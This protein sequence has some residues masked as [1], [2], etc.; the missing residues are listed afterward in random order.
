MCFF[1]MLAGASYRSSSSIMIQALGRYF[2]A[3]TTTATG[4]AAATALSA[5]P[6]W[7]VGTT[8]HAQGTMITTARATANMQQPG[9]RNGAANVVI[10]AANATTI[11]GPSGTC[12]M[13]E[14][15]CGKQEC[16]LDSRLG[17]PGTDCLDQRCKGVCEDENCEQ[18]RT[19][20]WSLVIS[21]ET[22]MQV[23]ILIRGESF[24]SGQHGSREIG[25]LEM[26]RA[27]KEASQSQGE[28]LLA[29]LL[30]EGF[31]LHLYL[32]TPVTE[33]SHYLADIYSAYG[34]I[35][36]GY[37]A[38]PSSS[39]GAGFV[40]GLKRLKEGCNGSVL[41]SYRF[42]VVLRFDLIF[43]GPVFTVHSPYTLAGIYFPSRAEP[44]AWRKSKLVLD[45]LHVISRS[46]VEAF[47]D[48]IGTFGCF[49]TSADPF[50]SW[51]HNCYKRVGSKCPL[52][53]LAEGCYFGANQNPF[54]SILGRTSPCC[55][56]QG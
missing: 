53:F 55:N 41:Q 4:A 52:R 15:P 14:T 37:L 36:S 12:G 40:S 17:L 22:S 16:H 33:F 25:N 50:I 8:H 6:P 19:K 54:Y 26:V 27:Q 51:G 24:R 42:L 13:T 34:H 30:A 48:S 35:C 11:A 38:H 49:E 56:R 44:A 3:T 21:R 2:H 47:L 20:H 31:K 18:T 1:L 32:S 46:C 9:T 23:A 43:H 28:Y 10:A 45:G 29:P 5:Q 39:Q 7:N